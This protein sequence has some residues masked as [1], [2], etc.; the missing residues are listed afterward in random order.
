MHHGATASELHPIHQEN[1]KTIK[2]TNNNYH[3]DT[4]AV[5]GRAERGG[6]D[7]LA[8]ASKL[9]PKSLQILKTI[10]ITHNNYRNG[11]E[12]HRNM[13]ARLHSMEQHL[14][15]TGGGMH[16]GVIAL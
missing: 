9:D 13:P 7:H 3:N 4:E 8:N 1:E 11:L 12:I 5:G 10:T 14:V 2:N 6:I 16:H 15:I